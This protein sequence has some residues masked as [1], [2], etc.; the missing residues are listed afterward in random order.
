MAL[1]IVVVC[2]LFLLVAV[3]MV[4][5]WGGHLVRRPADPGAPVSP[6][7]LYLWWANVATAA[8]LASGI[9]VAWAGGRLAMRILA[10]TSPASAQGRLTEA[11]ANVGF[12]TIEGSIA[13]LFFG[14]LPAGFAAAFIYLFIRRWLPAGRWAGPTLGVLLLLVFGASV[15]PLRAENIDFAIVGPGWLSVI[16]FSALAVLHGAVVAAVAGAFSQRLPLPTGR[17]WKYYLPLVGAILFPPAGILLG[18]GA[19]VVMLCLWLAHFGRAGREPLQTGPDKVRSARA[20]RRATAPSW[21][22]RAALG[23]A[24]V[25]ALPPFV[26]AVTSIISR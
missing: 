26:S 21:G 12:P 18:I 14:G 20:L 24:A 15:D 8:A 5:V 25:V 16:L 11:Q 22:G 23:L 1:A 3:I 13:L 4:I 10:A 2:T 7:R 9:L 17:D 6:L 19:L